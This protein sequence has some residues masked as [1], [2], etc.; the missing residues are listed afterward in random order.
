MSFNYSSQP[1]RQTGKFAG[2]FELVESKNVNVAP[3]LQMMSQHF[4]QQHWHD[5]EQWFWEQFDFGN[6]ISEGGGVQVF[7]AIIKMTGQH[8]ALKIPSG[9]LNIKDGDYDAL[10][11]EPLDEIRKDFVNE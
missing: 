1:L 5:R 7:K 6:L 2:A 8:V 4:V 3:G 11:D 9:V 10:D